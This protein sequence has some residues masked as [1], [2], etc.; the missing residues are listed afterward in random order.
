MKANTVACVATQINSY[1]DDFNYFRAF[2]LVKETIKLWTVKKNRVLLCDC[3][4]IM[5]KQCK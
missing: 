3:A 5:F 1:C 4:L 2:G